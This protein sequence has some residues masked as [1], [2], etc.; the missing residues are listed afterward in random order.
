[1]LHWISRCCCNPRRI[2]IFQPTV[3]TPCTRRVSVLTTSRCC[4]H[5]RMTFLMVFWRSRHCYTLYATPRMTKL[6]SPAGSRPSY[7]SVKW[8]SAILGI[9]GTMKPTRQLSYSRLDLHLIARLLV[10]IRCLHCQTLDIL[11]AFQCTHASCVLD[12]RM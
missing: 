9:D 3:E 10:H 12:G 5:V 11:V 8:C 6:V 4:C 1:M 7:T 2:P